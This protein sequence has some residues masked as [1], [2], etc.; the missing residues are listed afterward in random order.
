MKRT[1]KIIATIALALFITFYSFM[2]TIVAE[3]VLPGVS[4]WFELLFYVVA[5]LIWVLPAGFIIWLGWRGE[6]AINPA[7]VEPGD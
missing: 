6:K 2:I 3:L 4:G 5:G 7:L 1:R